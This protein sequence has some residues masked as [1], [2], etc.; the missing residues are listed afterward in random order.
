[1]SSVAPR[2]H[3]DGHICHSLP[4]LG[5]DEHGMD[6]ETFMALLEEGWTP[7]GQIPELLTIDRV[8]EMLRARST[9]GAR[10]TE[11]PEPDTHVVGAPVWL[12]ATVERFIAERVVPTGNLRVP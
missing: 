7:P 5:A 2:D 12:R 10:V 8:A 11:L 1:M 9:T 3:L 6:A 4:R